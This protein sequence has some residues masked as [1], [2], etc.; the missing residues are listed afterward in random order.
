MFDTVEH[1]ADP[2][3]KPAEHRT[4]AIVDVESFTDHRRNNKHQ[5]AIRAALYLSLRKAFTTAGIPWDSCEHFDRGDS[6]FI[7]APA[8]IPKALFVDHLPSTLAAALH[9]HNAES[10]TEEHIRL[11]MALHAGEVEFDEH[12]PTSMAIN[13]TFRLVETSQLKRALK[14]SPGVLALAVS[15]WYFQEVVRHCEHVRPH[16]FVRVNVDVSKVEPALLGWISLPE[17]PELSSS[18][19]I[20]EPSTTGR[21]RR[22]LLDLIR[23]RSRSARTRR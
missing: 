5:K 3:A 21:P 15:E 13:Q 1:P 4:I 2:H 16:T 6:I 7:L 10:T 19:V 12:G 17:H 9:L 22:R 14:A 18:A 11:R 8:G 20:D 23:Q